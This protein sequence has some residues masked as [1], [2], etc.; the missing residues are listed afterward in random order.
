MNK[1]A[2]DELLTARQ[3]EYLND[4]LDNMNE[5]F[6]TY[7]RE[8]RVTFINKKSTETLG[9]A[10][11]EVV[12]RYGWDF[13][14]ERNREL[15]RQATEQ[16]L[17]TGQRDSYLVTVLRKDGSERVVRLNASPIVEDGIISGEM[18]LAEDVSES[19]RTEKALKRNNLELQMIKEEL[20]A[21]NEQLKAT[22]EELMQQLDES[23]NNKIALA[24]A[25]QQMEAIF[26]FLPDPAFVVDAAGVVQMWN[27]AMEEVTGVKIREM[28]GKGNREYARVFY[29]TRRAMLIDLALEEI[30]PDEEEY[31]V[32]KN[33]RKMLTAEQRISQF[34]D[35]DIYLSGKSSPIYDH[36][37]E[38]MGAIESLRDI[39]DSRKA[40][41]AIEESEEK[42]RNIIDSIEDGY[43]EVD[44]AG[45]FQFYN[46]W[47]LK[48]LGYRAEELQGENYQL[49]MDELNGRKVFSAF[50]RVYTT[51]QSV[52]ELDWQVRRK[53]GSPLLVE[54]TVLPIKGNG[55]VSGF[56]GIVHDI[57]ERKA[58]EEALKKSAN[59]YRTIFETT[60]TATIIIEADMTVSLMNSEMQKLLGYQKEEIEGKIKWTSL[61]D[62]MDVE[63]MAGYHVLRRDLPDN[64][65]R[66]YEFRLLTRFRGKRDVVLTIAMIPGTNQ[67]VA[68]ILDITDRKQAE[69]ALQV[70]EARYRAIVEDQ[71][72][73]ICRFLPDGNI[74]FV[75][76]TYCR[77]F[78]QS[79]EEVLGSD[80]KSVFAAEDQEIVNQ[81]IND[82]SRANPVITGE[83]QLH[84]AGGQVRWQQWTHRAIFNE[85]G[86]LLDYQSVGR[87][88]TARKQAEERLRYLSIHDALTGLYN[89]LYFQ[90]QMR[91]MESGELNPV[92]LIMCDVDGLK[93]VNDTLGHERGDKLLKAAA[94]L[95]ND[96]F[97]NNDVVARVGGDEFA[98]L[99]PHT[100]SEDAENAILRIRDKIR[101]Y[102][103]QYPEMHLSIS[104]GFALKENQR[105][106]MA[107][108]FEEAD[109]NMYHDKLRSKLN[110]RGS[111]IQTLIKALETRDFI[112]EGHGERM[113][114]MVLKMARAL[115]LPE[116]TLHE[117]KLLAQFHDIGKV[118]VSDDILFK[119]GPLTVEERGQ[120][121]RHCEIGNRIAFSAPEL[122]L[123]ADWILKHHEW[124][125]G[126]GYP[127]GLMGDDIPLECRMLAIAD[128]YDAL[129]SDRPY[130]QAGPPEVAVEELRR[131]AGTQFDP[132]LVEKFIELL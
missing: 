105:A 101:Q 74:S 125:N 60:G 78:N 50:N 102:N 29:G 3:I 4:L 81:Q 96:C 89:R 121:K 59:L 115:E 27:R 118:G 120:M 88:V 45:N 44:L 37:G 40:Q 75:N 41:K 110:T 64:A 22:E 56:R 107:S 119:K 2:R 54:T 108:V 24:N 69:D 57:S 93:I 106:S 84:L 6:Y 111:I 15:F 100:T 38:L 68:S 132:R 80:F 20:T 86:V 36:R 82:L 52:K 91:V 83:T 49:I 35:A 47:L 19:R 18:V 71:T 51:G 9:Y 103:L 112:T 94:H 62:P 66:N 90:E 17:K 128:A 63:R 5:L 109:N 7:D 10:P 14:P 92:G 21:A 122:V 117:I 97:R 67:S 70:S 30:E 73:L 25:H 85:Q 28:L 98:I 53:D 23:E 12:G 130:R 76:E 99:L 58:A 72:E 1:R 113:E 104:L 123:I 48:V 43:F 34:G 116:R 79:R 16:R 87:D 42:Y 8:G 11:E 131:A 46:P 126:E 65:P 31:I 129:T 124:W 13:I 55:V 114:N 26:N 127:L 77:Y 32:L 33:E 61:I 95:L 39:T